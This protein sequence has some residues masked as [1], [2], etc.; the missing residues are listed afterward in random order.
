MKS[1]LKMGKNDKKIALIQDSLLI[2]GGSER[3]FQ[4][5]VEAFPDADIFTLAYNPLTTWPAFKRYQ[6]NTSWAN[7]FIQSHAR[8]KIL[9]PFATQVMKNWELKGYDVVLSSSATVA[10]YVSRIDGLHVCYCYYPTRAIWN[11]D[12]YFNNNGLKERA[13]R[14]VLPHLRKQDL[15]AAQN[16]DQF[17]AISK[18]TQAAIKEIYGLPSE[19]MSCPIDFDRFK[20]GRYE[21]KMDYFLI[22]SRLEHWKQVGYAIEAFNK[23]G[24]P[25]KIIGSGSEEIAL[26]SIAKDNIHFLGDVDDSTLAQEYGRAKAVIFTPELEYGLVPLEANAAGT[27]VIALGKGGVTETMVPAN[28]AV[29]TSTSPTAVF[30]DEPS[31][32]AL[33]NAIRFF[34]RVEF[35]RDELIAHA[36]RYSIPAFKSQIQDYIDKLIFDE[37]EG[38]K[39]QRTVN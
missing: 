29:D 24:L 7:P 13:F 9:F 36:S 14:A 22:V 39:I 25:L 1:D 26:K 28:N 18:A 12:G 3:I 6:I 4:Y 34:D 8:F 5:M 35:D 30:F 21:E 37:K 11:P 19:V 10:K 23:L 17:I 16:V 15:I 2:K 38:E 32:T 27:P 31:S 20:H 33:S